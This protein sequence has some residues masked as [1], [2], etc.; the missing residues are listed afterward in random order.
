MNLKGNCR[1]DLITISC[2]E[3]CANLVSESQ[4]LVQSFLRNL[5]WTVHRAVFSEKK[6]CFFGSKCL[7]PSYFLNLILIINLFTGSLILQRRIIESV[8]KILWCDNSNETSSTSWYY[9]FRMQFQLLSLCS[10]S[11]SVTI[12]IKSLQ[13]YLYMVLFK[14]L[15]KWKSVVLSR[16]PNFIAVQQVMLILWWSP[17]SR[18]L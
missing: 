6:W 2:Q 14:P 16:F 10:K 5:T 12:Q 9:V 13:Q 11:D 18:K 15:W 7:L 1:G 4:D 17:D 8:V 3:S